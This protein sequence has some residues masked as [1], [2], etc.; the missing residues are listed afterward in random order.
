MKNYN[1]VLGALSGEQVG[2]SQPWAEWNEYPVP[3][4]RRWPGDA[5]TGGPM[6]ARYDGGSGGSRGTDT[7]QKHERHWQYDESAT[8]V[9]LPMG[10]YNEGYGPMTEMSLEEQ[11]EKQE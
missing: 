6:R 3:D 7:T 11:Q 9:T 5:M 8:A 10:T 1:P 4:Q 2:G